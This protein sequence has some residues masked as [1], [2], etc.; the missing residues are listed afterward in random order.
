MKYQISKLK[1]FGGALVLL[2]LVCGCNNYK[3]YTVRTGEKGVRT[4][5]VL[6]ALPKTEICVDVTF[7]HR[8]T[9]GAPYVDYAEEM[10]AVDAAGGSYSI[11]D[12]KIT[13]RLVADPAHYYYVSPGNVGV[14]VDEHH[15]LRSI[16][17]EYAEGEMRGDGTRGKTEGAGVETG[18]IEQPEY[19][20]YDRQDTFYRRGDR[21]GSPTMLSS[22][23]DSRS[24][25]QRAVAAAERIGNI[26]ERREQLLLGEDDGGGTPE[27][28]RYQL[29]MLERQEGM[30]TEQ[31]M[32]REEEET[33]RFIVTPQDGR[34]A[35]ER[36]TVVL[37]YFSPAGGIV[38]SGAADGE[39]V[40]CD[41]YCE[42]ELRGAA[43]F[44]RHHTGDATA[45]DKRPTFKYRCSEMAEVTVRSKGFKYQQSLAVSQYGPI[46][47]LPRSATRAVFDTRTGN[48]LFVGKN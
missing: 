38:D 1:R 39:A 14:S 28:V 33:V 15:L 45:L 44:V 17:M 6:Y 31:F 13:S 16:G 37:F 34:G 41:I 35:E 22:K 19:N 42:K 30:L 24:L 3:V 29:E 9:A 20:L 4:G 11:A 2:L 8:D 36:Q 10:L 47:E 46:M 43:R 21:P 23:K 7:R 32:G 48:L 25:R 12:V 18:L 5:G 27:M 26:Q 40:V